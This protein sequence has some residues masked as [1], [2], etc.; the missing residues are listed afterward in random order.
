MKYLIKQ[1]S[2]TSPL[3]VYAIILHL[4]VYINF[5]L[6]K[7]EIFQYSNLNYRTFNFSI[8]I[9]AFHIYLYFNIVRGKKNLL[10]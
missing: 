8:K 5:I 3:P 4:Q 9:M 10:V 6:F 1:K 7:A 2:A